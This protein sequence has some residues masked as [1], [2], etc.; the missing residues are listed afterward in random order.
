MP[1][2]RTRRGYNNVFVYQIVVSW[3]KIW[4]RAEADIADL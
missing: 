4:V 3:C 2:F 1:G